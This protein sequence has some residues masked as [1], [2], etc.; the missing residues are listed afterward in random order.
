M[1]LLTAVITVDKDLF[2][3]L[4]GVDGSHSK[5]WGLSEQL[6][7]NNLEIHGGDQS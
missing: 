6:F 1:I 3:A 7:S 5:L 2:F 4:S